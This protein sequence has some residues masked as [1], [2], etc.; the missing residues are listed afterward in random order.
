MAAVA[1]TTRFSFAD[2]VTEPAQRIRRDFG[3]LPGL[4]VTLAQARRL[5]ALPDGTCQ[6][7]LGYLVEQRFLSR[8]PDG[9]YVLRESGWEC[10]TGVAAKGQ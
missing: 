5:W 7:L 6:D 2:T 1:P 10:P 9:R 3:L 4:A 8:R